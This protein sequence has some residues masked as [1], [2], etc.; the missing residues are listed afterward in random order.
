MDD[1]ADKRCMARLR[2]GDDLALNDLMQ[3]WKE[4]LVT[5]CLRY[6]GNRTDARE[7]AQETFVKV[8]KA[9]NRYRATEAT[10]S[11]WLFG[12]ANNLC[13]MRHRWKKRHPEILEADRESYNTGGSEMTSDSPASEV[14]RRALARDLDQAIQQL[15]HDLRSAFIFSQLQGKSQSEIALIQNTTT[16]AIERRLARAKEKLRSLLSQ[17]WGEDSL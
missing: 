5:F 6:T 9:R 7:I 11:T 4:P 2:E 17:K 10:F 8:Y 16:K 12:I 3:R 15:P 1:E 14:D 13:R